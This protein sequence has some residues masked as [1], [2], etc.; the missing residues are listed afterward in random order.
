MTELHSTTAAVLGAIKTFWAEEGFSPS[1]R[2]I[3]EATDISSSSVV[4]YHILELVRAGA[5]ERTPRVA[6]SY[7]P[8]EKR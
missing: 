3:M 5:I 4:R 1:I 6:R 2:D 8:I 7:V